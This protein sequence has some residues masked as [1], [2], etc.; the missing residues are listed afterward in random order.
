MQ[1]IISDYNVSSL[2]IIQYFSRIN[3][4]FLVKL[5]AGQ[6]ILSKLQL[7]L[8]K[9]LLRLWITELPT[10]SQEIQVYLLEPDVLQVLMV[11]S[12]QGL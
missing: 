8:Q 12:G 7:K 10:S 4:G 3:L 2:T 9:R 11:P 1:G 5:Q 6:T